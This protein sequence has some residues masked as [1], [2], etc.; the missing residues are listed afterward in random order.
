L[1]NLGELER[2]AKKYAE[3]KNSGNGAEVALLASSIVDFVSLPTFSFPLKG[4]ALSNDGTTTYVY[5]DNDTFPALCDFFGE[6][7]HS[8]VPLVIRDAKFGPGEIIINN[9]NR[10][11]ADAELGR[12]V[13][14][15]QELVHAKKSQIFD[16]YA[17]T[18]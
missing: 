18:A 12:C 10:Q 17:D 9:G 6:L 4:E 11:E 5:V 15:L 14:E 2:I 3:L 8:P 13:R 7:L 16:R 1:T